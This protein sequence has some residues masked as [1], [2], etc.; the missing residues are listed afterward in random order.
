MRGSADDEHLRG[1]V[2]EQ[3]AM[4]G[5]RGYSVGQRHGSDVTDTGQADPAGGGQCDQVVQVR[6]AVSGSPHERDGGRL[7]GR[8]KRRGRDEPRGRN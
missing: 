3:L 7:C 6:G 1:D 5:E 2:G 8:D 4:V